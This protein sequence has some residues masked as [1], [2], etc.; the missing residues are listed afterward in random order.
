MITV[1]RTQPLGADLYP[2][3][4]KVSIL[5]FA[6]GRVKHKGR[7]HERDDPGGSAAE[8]EPSCARRN[9]SIDAIGH[10]IW[11]AHDGSTTKPCGCAESAPHSAGHWA[12]ISYLHALA[13]DAGWRGRGVGRPCCG[14]GPAPRKATRSSWRSER[15][16]GETAIRA[17]GNKVS[18][19]VTQHCRHRLASARSSRPPWPYPAIPIPSA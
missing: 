19:G 17:M 2:A 14:N 6:P 16:G 3:I 1:S 9:A 10:N 15:A 18:Q 5:L 7:R 13:V 12:P 4:V 8:T 11:L